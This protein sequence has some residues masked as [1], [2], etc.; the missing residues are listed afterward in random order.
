MLTSTLTKQVYPLGGGAK[1]R[2][3]KA[4]G[5]LTPFPT[6]FWLCCPTLKAAVGNLERDGLVRAFEDRLLRSNLELKRMQAAHEGYAA[7]RWGSLEP[8]DRDLCLAEGANARILTSLRDSGVGGL[9]WRRHGA[10]RIKCL[11][12]HYAQFLASAPGVGGGVRGCRRGNPV[13]QWVHDEIAR[14]SAAAAGAG[15]GTESK[16]AHGASALQ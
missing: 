4:E 8:C 12:L 6:I 15:E 3:A 1:R 11:H 2:R 14:R 7:Q 13:G 5:N 10:H 9:D 16:A